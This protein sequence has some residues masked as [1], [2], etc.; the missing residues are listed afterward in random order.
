MTEITHTP[1][2][3]ARID[4]RSKWLEDNPN[5]CKTCEGRGYHYYPQ[6]RHEPESFD[7]CSCIEDGLC[8]RCSEGVD[9][10]EATGVST[11][12]EC[13]W[14]DEAFATGGI[15]PDDFYAPDVDCDCWMRKED[16][17]L[18]SAY[19]DRTDIGDW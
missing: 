14:T 5:H 13:H 9:F 7:P 1:S 3:Q 2:C 18:E 12:P 16:D 4:A 15:M 19:E 17:W 8:P 6:T 11:C 10:D